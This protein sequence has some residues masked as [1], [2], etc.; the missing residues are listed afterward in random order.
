MG[1]RCVGERKDRYGYYYADSGRCSISGMRSA[2]LHSQGCGD[3][4]SRDCDRT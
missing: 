1:Q 4:L 3:Y 2:A